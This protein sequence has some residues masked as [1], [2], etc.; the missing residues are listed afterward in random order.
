MKALAILGAFLLGAAMAA[1]TTAYAIDAIADESSSSN[2]LNPLNVIAGVNGLT[3]ATRQ[4]FRLFDGP[5]GPFDIYQPDVL[6]AGVGEY[7]A[8]TML[9]ENAG[10][11]TIYVIQ[12]ESAGLPY[13]LLE[14]FRPAR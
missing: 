1:A 10:G 7:P 2:D 3:E 11:G 6:N 8:L 13:G 9:S 14:L 12:P 5:A 4:M